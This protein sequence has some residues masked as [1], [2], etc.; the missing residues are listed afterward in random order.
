MVYLSFM[1]QAALRYPNSDLCVD[2]EELQRRRDAGSIAA[3]AA[4]STSFTDATDSK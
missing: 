4:T 1:Q 2:S 3:A